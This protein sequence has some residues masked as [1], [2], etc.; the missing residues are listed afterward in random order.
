M[1]IIDAWAAE[2]MMNALT[3]KAE[4]VRYC[5]ECKWSWCQIFVDKYGKNKTYWKCLNW[6]GETD[7]EGYCHK[8]EAKME[9]QE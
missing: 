9:E 3:I 6:D 2:T 8:W 1:A 7:E 5:R 4:P